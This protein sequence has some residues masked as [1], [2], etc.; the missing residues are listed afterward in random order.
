MKNERKKLLAS[1]VEGIQEKK[2]TKITQIDLTGIAGTICDY[3]IVCEGGSPSQIN[4]I[5]ESVEKIVR[6]NTKVSPL[7]IQGQ[8]LGEWI[9]IDYG[10]VIVHVFLP[11]IRKHYNIESLWS[12]AGFENF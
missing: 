7:R 1:I 10:D 6:E 9:G 12:D 4:A 11:E 8:R 5:A 3:F 2:G